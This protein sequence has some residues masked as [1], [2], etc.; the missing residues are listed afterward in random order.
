MCFEWQPHR[1]K[2]IGKVVVGLY[3]KENLLYALPCASVT[4]LCAG[5]CGGV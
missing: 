4:G 3:E 5:T 1:W 2:N